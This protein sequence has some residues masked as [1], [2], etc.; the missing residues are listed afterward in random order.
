MNIIKMF[1]L[2]A[3]MS[4]DYY[5]TTSWRPYYGY[6]W[7]NIPCH[8]AANVSS[9]RQTCFGRLELPGGR[10]RLRASFGGLSAS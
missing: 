9:Y 10:P 4:C 6:V 1:R 8:H 2:T 7:P 5:D 3:L